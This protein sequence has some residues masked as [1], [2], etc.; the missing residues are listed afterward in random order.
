MDAVEAVA[1]RSIAGFRKL[2]PALAGQLVTD[3]ASGTNNGTG[4]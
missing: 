4:I 2:D 3:P 1:E